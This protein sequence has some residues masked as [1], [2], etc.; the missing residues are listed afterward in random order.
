M[1]QAGQIVSEYPSIYGLYDQRILHYNKLVNDLALEASLTVDVIRKSS[2]WI[3]K[4][5]RQKVNGKKV[6]AWSFSGDCC[7]TI[8]GKFIWTVDDGAIAQDLSEYLF[9]E[10]YIYVTLCQISDLDR[11]ICDEEIERLERW[12]KDLKRFHNRV[13]KSEKRKFACHVI[14]NVLK[15][16]T[17]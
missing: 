10:V 3:R 11:Q 7:L 6:L 13:L 2:I 14:S 17:K 5:F 4:S 15:W 16:L 8:D 9:D 1:D 12:L